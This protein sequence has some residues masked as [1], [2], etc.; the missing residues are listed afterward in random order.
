MGGRSAISRSASIRS[1]GVRS[2]SV[3]NALNSLPRAGA[4]RNGR[5]L[6][7]PAA[8]AQIAAGAALA[9]WHYRSAAGGW[10]QHG[11]GGYGWVGPVFWPF[12]YYDI[13]DYAMW[14]Y[15]F[16]APF[17]G[18]GYPDIYAGI[19]AP[20]G[21]DDLAGYFYSPRRS[22]GRR[23]AGL[24]RMALM[25]GDDSRDVAGLPIDQIQQVV[26]PTEPQRAALD[27]LANVSISAAQNIRAACP[28]QMILT[29]PARLASMQQRIG[30]MRGAVA[31]VQPSLEKFYDLLNDDQKARLNAAAEDQRRISAA[32]KP[33][34]PLAQGCG[35]AQPAAMQWP[36]GEIE[37]RLSPTGTQR[38]SLETLQ[39]ASAKAADMLKAS[40]QPDDA[41]TPP[42]RLT[43]AGKRLDTMLQAVKLVGSA[44]EDFYATLS[45]EQRAQFE[46]IGPRR[47]S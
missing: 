2:R 16:G 41:I 24:D 13:Y 10:W 38:A 35:V 39:D 3:H 11:N 45:D 17:W 25:C 14:G 4:L 28:T 46:A 12:A 26:Q 6:A 21:Y 33:K 47:T 36:T 23:N 31:M 27:E 30:A 44:L 22:S 15:G 29:A 9:G 8:R 18:Y 19:F 43:A 34:E 37:A 20:Y 32:K 5:V 7:S 40:C 1:A 42:A